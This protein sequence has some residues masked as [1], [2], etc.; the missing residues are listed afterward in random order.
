MNSHKK[1]DIEVVD[2]PH[3]NYLFGKNSWLYRAHSIGLS[4]NIMYIIIALSLI[5]TIT[6]IFG[7]GL[8]LPIFQFIRMEGDLSALV[9]DSVIWQ[10]MVNVFSYLNIEPT[11]LILLL[12][13]FFFFLGRQFFLY[14]RIVYVKAVSQRLNQ[15][16]RN[17]LFDCYL[18]ADMTYHD[19]TPVGNFVNIIMTEVGNAVSG[20]MAPITLTVYIVTFISYILVLFMLSWQM[21]IVSTIVLLIS[22]QVPSVWVRQSKIN[23]RKIVLANTRMSEF[24]VSRLQ[25]PR[26]VR[27]AATKEIEKQEFCNLTLLQRKCYMFGAILKAKT[28]VSMDPVVISLSLFLFYFSYTVLQ[29]QIEIIG[30]YLVIML[31]LMP[32]VQS[33]IVEF[34]NIQSSLGSIEIL[35]GR[36][37]AMKKS[38]E[39]DTGTIN[40]SALKQSIV[41]NKVY[42]RYP[43]KSD[44]ALKDI[45]IEFKIG[46]LTAVVGPSGGGKSTLVDLLPRLRLPEKG[47]IQVDGINIKNYILRD[48]RRLMSYAPQFPQIFNGTIKNH[49]LYGKADATDEEV[50]ESAYLSGAEEF[51]NQLSEGFD[52]IVGEG[53]VRLS[54]GQRQRLDLARV[55]MKKSPILILDEPT[56]NLDVESENIFK[57]SIDRIR[58][59]TNTSIIIIS[60]KLLSI[61]DAD[62]I[63]VIKQG[64]IEGFG[65]HLELLDQDGWY[66][67]AWNTQTLVTL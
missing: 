36:I 67:E 66:S 13:S 51:I 61:A 8:F 10:Y 26:L 28:I 58:K 44:Y 47:S 15:G 24:L 41:L 29:L 39:E 40:L 19:S 17:L 1:Q 55:L 33:I 27:L 65:S 37:S 20:I 60:H 2:N 34:Q 46:E 64:K 45:S 6:E 50:R 54:G 63:I 31:R 25:S 30:V 52:T 43:T 32:I 48:L 14:V 59:E 53:A 62:N 5:S 7:I 49:I 22:S 9:G 12:I 16:R 42:Y 3:K 57:S 35:E 18:D 23:G 11:L 4:N 38:A 56:S 21:T